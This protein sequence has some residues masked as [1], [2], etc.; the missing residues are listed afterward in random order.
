MEL[1]NQLR[2]SKSR[3]SIFSE[4]KR[5]YYL[6]YYQHWGGWEKDAPEINRLAYR[7]GK[8]LSMPMLVGT[9][10]HEVLARHFQG[11]RMGSFRE[12]RAEQAVEKM[13][14]VWRNAKKELWRSN[15][16]R[17][18]PLFEIYYKRVPPAQDLRDYA[19]SARRV[20][21]N[22]KQMPVY[23]S[24]KALPPDGFLW[25][26]PAH[27]RFSEETC[28]PVPP[29]E[30]I[31]APDLVFRQGGEIVIMDWKTGKE[32]ESDR[33]QMA[34]AALWARH[35]IQPEGE[36]MKAVL[37]YL[38]SSSSVDF[39][40]DD[41]M[42]AGAEQT[43]IREMEAMSEY[44]KDASKNIPLAREEF[45]GHNNVNFCRHCEFQEICLKNFPEEN[46]SEKKF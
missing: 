39:A 44:L 4:C 28:F 31:S 41:E 19:D 20:I 30:A 25:I 22:L 11:M 3:S 5:K 42:M 24:L 34:A 16:K 43:I 35:R 38:K 1:E 33:L 46:V 21:A 10:V 9:A 15:P 14:R 23:L 2:W 13:R 40:I 27:E 6:R 45:P 36:R 29:F 18:P 17:Y 26:D 37:V 7:L 8:I 12:L 32:S